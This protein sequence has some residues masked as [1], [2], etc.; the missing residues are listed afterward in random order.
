MVCNS[1]VVEVTNNV[2]FFMGFRG[3]NGAGKSTTDK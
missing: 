1:I 2:K 3:L